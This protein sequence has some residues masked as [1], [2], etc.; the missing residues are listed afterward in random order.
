MLR[1]AWKDFWF[2]LRRPATLMWAFVMP[3]I[4][5]AFIGKVTGGFS[6]SFSRVDPLGVLL[7]ADA[8]FLSDELLRLL[9]TVKFQPVAVKSAAELQP[10]ERRLKVP[11][12]FTASVLAGRAVKLSLTRKGEESGADYE[13]LR[14]QRA[15]YSLLAELIAARKGGARATPEHLAALAAAPRNLQVEVE[16]AGKKKLIPSGF[17]QSVP[18]I[19]V[20]FVLMVMLTGGA[21][22]LVSERRL[23]ILRRLASSPLRRGEVV[24]A[25][26][27][28][29]FA[30]G[31]LQT[32]FA[33][34]TG[35][36]LFHVTW[37]D[38]PGAIFLL[39][40]GY[41]ALC[42]SLGV[43]FGSLVRKEGQAIGV[44]TIAGN[45]LA[46]LG[47][48]WWPIE[49]TP[50]WMQTLALGLPTGITQNGLHRLMTFGD[51]ALSVAPHI[52]A[53]FAMAAVVAWL[54]ARRFSFE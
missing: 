1:L 47:G 41:L 26:W 44:G 40:A 14:V 11:E 36:W 12:G 20:M 46:A 15:T 38:H 24:V 19:M 52:A 23:G 21:A 33:V 51:T 28:S 22:S 8:G 30:L 2:L 5:F 54:A 29:R 43:L 13:R 4:F 35:T 18:G 37:G 39:L 49:L 7:P 9:A 50:Q 10:F 53:L 31:V 17:Q 45:L 6:D 32:I 25:K 27:G 48:C 16:A 34:L 3:V 42:A